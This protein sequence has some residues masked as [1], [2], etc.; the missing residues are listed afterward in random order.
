LQGFFEVI[1][2]NNRGMM[3]VFAIIWMIGAYFLMTNMN[4]GAQRIPTPPVAAI[5]AQAQT[6]ANKAGD[7]QDKLIA[8]V[9]KYAEVSKYY[10]KTE[11]AAQARLQVGILQETRLVQQPG[12]WAKRFGAV[13]DPDVKQGLNAVRTYKTLIKDF[14][15]KKSDAAEAA[16]ARLSKLEKTIDAK[17]RHGIGYKI[18]DSLVALTGRDPNFSFA[19][20]LLIITIIVKV[21]TMPL[22]HLQYRSMR[23]MQKIQPL[24]KELQ[25]KYKGD[26]RALGE[27]TMALYKEHGVNPFSGCLPLLIQLPVLML[28]YYKV[29]MAYQFQFA[30]GKF[31]WIGSSLAHRLPEYA[32]IASFK[33]PLMAA[34]LAQPDLLLLLMY[35]VS[36]IISQKLTVVDPSQAEQQRIMT[37]TM[38]IM[39]TVILLSFPSALMLYWLFFNILSTVQQYLVLRKPADAAT[40]PAASTGGGLD[41]KPAKVK[42]G[43]AKTGKSGRHRKRFEALQ[44]A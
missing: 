1:M 41:I 20:A 2:N 42:A 33:I 43:A 29:I 5:L 24:L 38:P 23:E 14:S 3:W 30:M 22:S 32:T 8:A 10:P 4:R 19:I 17:N 12:W 26:Q 37:Y 16:E 44:P 28:L 15:P 7:D 21:V 25:E 18:I 31:L 35:T 11:E 13:A 27:K 40:P 39:F 36:M 34:N 6:M 9:K